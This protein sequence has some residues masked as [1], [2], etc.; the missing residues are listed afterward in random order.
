MLAPG[1]RRIACAALVALLAACG[2]APVGPGFYR[3]ERGDT[4]YKIARSNRQSVQNIVRWNNLSN[5][6]AIEVGQVLRVEPPTGTATA[7][8]APPRSAA[9]A[10][11]ESAETTDTASAPSS[12]P[13]AAAPSISLVWP[14]SGQVIRNFDGRNSKGIDIANAA[15]TPVVAAAP[16]TVVYAGNGLRGYGNLLIIK[17]NGDY[18]TAYAH[19]QA[20]FVKEG[21]SVAQGQKIAEMGSSDN[22][23]VMLHFELRYQGRS[24]DPTRELPAR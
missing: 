4:V 24:I 8:T 20:L 7:R 1:I 3:V 12:A 19:N 15:G 14:T 17:H 10:P 18:L 22:D 23:R 5:A 11:R 21:Q 16:G 13:A 9:T 2:S 6:D